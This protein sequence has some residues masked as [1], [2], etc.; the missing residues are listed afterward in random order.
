[1]LQKHFTKLLALLTGVFAAVRYLSYREIADS[2]VTRIPVLDSDTYIRWG[3]QLATSGQHPSGPFW[4]GP[5]YPQFIGWLYSLTGIIT[6]QSI[7]VAQMILSC[8]T[9]L[10]VLLVTRRLFGERSA[11][12]AG[13]LGI[14]YAPWLYFDGMILSASW[15]LF[16]NGMMLLLLIEF[17]GAMEDEPRNW[18]AWAIAGG[19]CAV[20][21]LARPSILPFAVLLAAFLAWRTFQHKLKPVFLLSFLLALIIVH[22]PMSI[23]NAREGGSPVF[24]TAS[25]GVNFFIGNREGASGVYDELD[26]IQ[27]FDAPAEAEG[28]RLEASKRVGHDV[29]LPEAAQIWQDFALRDIFS[30]KLGW[31]KIEL[32]K[33]WWTLRNEEVANNFSFRATQMINPVVNTLP[34]RW[35]V[36]L[37]LAVV[38]LIMFWSER[39]RLPLFLFY[40]LSYVGSILL[41]FSSSE[42][43]F[44]LILILLPLAGYG[45]HA[46]IEGFR[47]KHTTHVAIALIAYVAVLIPANAPSKTAHSQVY[48]RSDFA[49]VGTVAMRYDML[50]EAMAMFARALAVDPD[51]QPARLG[52]A[53]ALWRT[54]NF[55]QAREEYARAGVSP[56]D[57]L[58]GAP[59]DA[60]K[61]K[62]DSIR[63]VAGDSAALAELDRAIPNPES[64]AVRDLWVERAKLQAASGNYGAAYISMMTAHELD[65]VSPDWP[66][67][68][69]EYILQL[70]FP[71]QA[72]SLYG[73]AV[74]LYPAYAPARIQRGFLAL[75]VGNIDEAVRQSR[76]LDKIKIPN[77]SIRAQA[78]TLDSLLRETNW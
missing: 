78:R 13:L 40:A 50:T 58:S 75:E 55:D 20:S 44:P 76:E 24:V 17:G 37:P 29:T 41:F 16:L 23:R 49:N 30:D 52:L 42:Y 36:L 21:A 72:D 73:V 57:S 65:P 11:L 22:L 38:G 19:L 77:D 9:F 6:P 69:A 51:Y 1:M 27:T 39:K 67:W 12:I 14:L 34:V 26:F 18:W 61:A 15:I 32:K 60:L 59:L 25:G 64:L 62:L 54:K 43:R 33:L 2:V 5:G 28:Y 56:P 35:G 71:A 31:I 63:T 7:L 48:P 4:L 66:F 10:S 45:I 74:D 47:S 68:A 3:Y 8:A 53:E 46:V 70:D